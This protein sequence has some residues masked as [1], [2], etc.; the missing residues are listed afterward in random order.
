[1]NNFLKFEYADFEEKF[2]KLEKKLNLEFKNKDLL[3]QAFV[4]RSFLNEHPNFGLHNNERLEF[5]GDAILEYVVTERL[6]LSYPEKSEGELTSWR[7]AL[8]N[9]KILSRIAKGLGFGNFLL[10]SQGELKETGKARKYILADT[11]EAFIGSLYLDQ[12]V[13]ICKD[14]IE[15]N[16]MG[17][18]KQIIEEGLYKDSKSSFQEAAQEKKG[19]TPDYKVLD[20]E[21]P[22]HAKSFVVG[23]FL[24]KDLVAKG[25]GFSKQE[26]EED[27]AKKGLKV[28]KW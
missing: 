17:E 3:V 26:A 6:F 10:L 21:G 19:I 4:H 24:N 22:D 13:G 2:S 5:L 25:R 20:E 12:G 1:M 28:M 14:L 23:V 18:L 7:A 9:S 11:M 27:A 8:V 16:L 15:K